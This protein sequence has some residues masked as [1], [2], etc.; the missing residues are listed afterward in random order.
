MALANHVFEAVPDVI[1]NDPLKME[2]MV[3]KPPTRDCL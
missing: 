3:G 2:W 1:A